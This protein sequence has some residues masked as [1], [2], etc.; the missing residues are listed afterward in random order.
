METSPEISDSIIDNARKEHMLH[1][2]ERRNL[3]INAMNELLERLNLRPFDGNSYIT[4]SQ[5]I[6]KVSGIEDNN[7]FEE[8]QKYLGTFLD[9]AEFDAKV[10]EENYWNS[11]LPS[12]K[13]FKTASDINFDA[14]KLLLLARTIGIDIE[15]DD[16]SPTNAGIV[17]DKFEKYI[18][19]IRQGIDN[20]LIEQYKRI[21]PEIIK[22][23]PGIEEPGNYNIPVDSVNLLKIFNENNGDISSVIRGG[24]GGV[25]YLTT[26]QKVKYILNFAIYSDVD[27]IRTG[28]GLVLHDP[29]LFDLLSQINSIQ[30]SMGPSFNGG[31]MFVAHTG[32]IYTLP[33]KV[34][35][36]ISEKDE[37]GNF[38]TTQRN[39]QELLK[40]WGYDKLENI[41]ASTNNINPYRVST[42]WLS[43]TRKRESIS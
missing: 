9:L 10:D 11:F 14:N 12:I 1:L 43:R 16:I 23:N 24:L 4:E 3:N 29:N 21:I 8:R 2:A 18:P 25:K 17:L 30:Y 35:E 26:E 27:S 7:T 6:I 19:Q 37:L 31:I 20:W 13:V 39:T 42:K 28:E 5:K 22:Q 34:F 36:K 38:E 15:K 33:D 41:P 32:E 40:E